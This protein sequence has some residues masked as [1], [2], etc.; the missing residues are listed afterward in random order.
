M[1]GHIP[2]MVEPNKH[3]GLIIPKGFS[4]NFH[5][6]RVVTKAHFT[7]S[8]N[9]AGEQQLVNT[10]SNNQYLI[11]KVLLSAL[12]VCKYMHTFVSNLIL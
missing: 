1:I 2:H 12:L 6:D 3:Q 11:S 9:T 10:G 8:S 7:S 4:F 5:P